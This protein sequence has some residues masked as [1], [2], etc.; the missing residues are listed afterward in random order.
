MTLPAT[1]PT[2]SDG[3][4]VLRPLRLDDADDVTLC[5]QDADSQRFTHVPVPYTRDDAVAWLTSHTPPLLDGATNPTW[6]IT[7]P[8][9]TGDRWGGSINLEPDPGEPAGV[10]YMVAPWLRGRGAATG[11]L[12]LACRWGFD[13]LGLTA[14]NWFAHLGNA[15]SRRVAEKAGF[16]IDPQ[17]HVGRLV[18]GVETDY[19]SGRVTAGELIS[20]TS[21]SGRRG[22]AGG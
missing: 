2:L 19:W 17:P 5:C 16:R 12:R 10:G 22:V 18:R 9:L 15:A 11:A 4:V 21:A 13:R 20:S 8:D 7:V 14:I 3:W 1:L 6:A